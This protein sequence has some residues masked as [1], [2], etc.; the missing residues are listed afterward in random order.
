M[1]LGY[2]IKT[3]GS[4]SP[5]SPSSSAFQYFIPTWLDKVFVGETD[6]SET[7]AGHDFD[8]LV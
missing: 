1:F 4:A 2:T 3:I 7:S 5:Q 8:Y 6:R